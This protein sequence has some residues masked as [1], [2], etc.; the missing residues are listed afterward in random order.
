MLFPGENGCI[1]VRISCM[2]I[3]P[4]SKKHIFFH[5][6]KNF[7]NKYKVFRSKLRHAFENVQNQN[8]NQKH[9]KKI[10]STKTY[11]R[12]LSKLERKSTELSEL[13]VFMIHKWIL[14]KLLRKCTAYLCIWHTSSSLLTVHWMPSRMRIFSSFFGR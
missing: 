9:N 12:A 13:F 5:E 1:S 2:N 11:R 10:S 3:K 8:K 4:F 7:W 6:K 14:M